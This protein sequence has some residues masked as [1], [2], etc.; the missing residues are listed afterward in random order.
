MNRNGFGA[1][2]PGETEQ[3]MSDHD[4]RR[5]RFVDADMTAEEHRRR[6]DNAE[7]LFREL[8]RRA[9]GKDRPW[10]GSGAVSRRASFGIPACEANTA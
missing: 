2:L 4:R 10:G 7:A 3:C 5:K 1:A 6:G 9:T 8:V